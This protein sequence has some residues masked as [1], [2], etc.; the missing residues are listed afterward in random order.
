[1]SFLS[2]A[3]I[4]PPGNVSVH[5]LSPRQILVS[6]TPPE[7]NAKN[8]LI[9]IYIINVTRVDSNG[10]YTETS[11]TTSIILSVL[12]FRYYFISVAAVTVEAG[13]FSDNIAVETPEEGK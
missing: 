2:A 6:W 12:P 11:N 3:P 10:E 13:P 9:R 4:L 7:E 1:M 8:G 5:V